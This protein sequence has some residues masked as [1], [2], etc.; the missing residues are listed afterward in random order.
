MNGRKILIVED[1]MITALD[2]SNQV[3]RLG[4][5]V[6]ATVRSGEEAVRL[7]EELSP[8]LV[9]MDVNLAGAMNG[10]EASRRIHL[11]RSIPV[12]FLTAYP[13]VFLDDP[14]EMQ[15]PGLCIA[16][17]CSRADLRSVLNVAL[18]S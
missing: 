8:D 3:R 12:V 10:L 13:Q 5:Y 17:P 4:H 1:E 14:T 18:A 9:I 2:L 7:A 15:P 11:K 16:K 6:S